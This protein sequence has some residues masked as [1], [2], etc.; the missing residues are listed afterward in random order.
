MGANT[1][2]AARRCDRASKISRHRHKR[3]PVVLTPEGECEHGTTSQRSPNE[4]EHKPGWPLRE[5]SRKDAPST[6]EGA[7]PWDPGERL[8]K[9]EA[10]ESKRPIEAKDIAAGIVARSK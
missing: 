1:T 7:A 5:P 9:E 8:L 2:A 6:W 10:F 3:K 4:G